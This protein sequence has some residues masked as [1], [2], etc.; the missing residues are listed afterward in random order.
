VAVSQLPGKPTSERNF[1]KTDNELD[2][3]NNFPAQ[4][5]IVR[6]KEIRFSSGGAGKLNRIGWLDGYIFPDSS[7]LN[8][9]RSV[10]GHNR[11]RR[12]L[13]QL[14]VAILNVDPAGTHRFD[15]YLSN[16]ESAGE[17]PIAPFDHPE[18]Q[19]FDLFRKC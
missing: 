6:H 4:A 12:R 10:E 18:T 7:V 5:V 15:E 16:R 8:G 14:S 3:S 1:V 9:G 11:N 2:S 13:K 17:E 19:S